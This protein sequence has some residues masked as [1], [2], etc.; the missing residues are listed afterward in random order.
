MPEAQEVAKEVV[1]VGQVARDL[2]LCVDGVPGP[3]EAVAASRRREMLGGK[4][5]NHAV[6]LVQLGV[7]VALLGVVGDDTVGGAL[8]A[9]ARADGL[10]V[11][12]VVRRPGAETGLV[13]DLVDADGHWHYVEHL[14]DEVLLTEDDV[15]AAADRLRAAACTVVQL[16]QPAP[17]ALAAATL[18]GGLVVLEGAPADDPR[19]DALLDAADVLRA[20][21]KEAGLLVG[22]ELTGAGDAIRAA[23]DLLSRHD[24]A[25][26]AFGVPEGDVFVWRDG[27]RA[28]E[29]GD[30]EVVDTT[31]A[32][33][34]LAA[35][36]VSVL[37]RGGDPADAARLAVAAAAAT[38][39]HPG[40]RPDLTP[41]RL[42]RFLAAARPVG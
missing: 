5:A 10:D 7:P 37:W 40:G 2:V 31:G 13:V 28:Y 11:G 41:D 15:A 33:D 16:Q 35:A 18:A 12:P 25:L 19:R 32:G 27:E 8:L 30:A 24:L 6:A 20:D 14:P 4:G 3:G 34:A 36:L 42:D 26:V 22:A 17:A 9:Q 23:R 21:A 29:H 1:V 39:E 38:V